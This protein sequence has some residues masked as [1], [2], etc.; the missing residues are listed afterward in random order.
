MPEHAI[1]VLLVEDHVLL[2]EILARTLSAEPDIEVIGQCGSVQAALE[3]IR[4][5][6]VDLVLLDINLG[7]ENG[8]SFLTQALSNGYRG[9][10]LVLTAGV[11]DRRAAWL[12]HRGSAGIVSKEEPFSV[13]LTRIRQTYA[14]I[15]EPGRNQR[16]R[17]PSHVA[18]DSRTASRLTARECHVLRAICEGLANK[19]IADRLSISEN[20]VKSFIQHLFDKTGVHTRAQLVGAAIEQYWDQL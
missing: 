6:D 13:L 4:S 10:V 19:E 2:R 11:D 3:L 7:S 9:R 1:R 18:R 15:I 8:G 20:T 12:M 17:E 14:A 16:P 5:R